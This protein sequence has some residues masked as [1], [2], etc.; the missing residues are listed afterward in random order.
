MAAIAIVFGAMETI[1]K[2]ND[3][4][5]CVAAWREKGEGIALVP[6]MGNLHTGHLVLV[7]QARQRARRIVVSLFVNPLQFGPAEDFAAY[8]R[9]LA[10]DREKLE[11]EGVDL[12][13]APG[14]GEVRRATLRRAAR[15]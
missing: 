10:A 3:L 8:P 1:A 12:L 5:A 15:R 9:T 11:R 7:R 4:R 14:V 2:L 6:T 13:F